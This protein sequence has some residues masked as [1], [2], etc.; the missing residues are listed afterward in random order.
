MSQIIQIM[1][2]DN[3]IFRIYFN[4]AQGR[5]KGAIILLHEI[6]GITDFIK[7]LSLEWANKGYHVFVPALYDRLGR[8]AVCSYDSKGYEQALAN[9]QQLLSQV[10][11]E[12]LTGYDI[13]LCDIEATMDYLRIHELKWIGMIGLSFG[14]TLA[15]LSACR[16]NDLK[17]VCAYYGTH[18][19][20]FIQ[21]IP[22][23]PM[24]MHC[25]DADEL[26]TITQVKEIHDKH[27]EV[28]INMYNAAHGFRC[29]DSQDY[30]QFAADSSDQKTFAFFTK[31][32]M[33]VE[34]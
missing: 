20:Q 34:A 10:N 25:G 15:W 12:G 24:L 9:K 33:V 28:V 6:F 18:I 21:E 19:Y 5:V 7:L 13:S 16:L 2:R 32:A 27:P 22:K 1:A 14:G 4:K 31:N 23:C 8:E 30:N 17:S 11:K 26:L 3:H 29:N